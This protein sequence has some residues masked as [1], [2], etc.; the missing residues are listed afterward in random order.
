LANYVFPFWPSEPNRALFNRTATMVAGRVIGGASAINGMVFHRGGPK[1]Y[2]AWENLGNKGWGW[3]DL[4]KY[5]IKVSNGG[6]LEMVREEQRHSTD[7][8]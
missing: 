6:Q 3:K 5:F 8:R 2:D 4:K 1:D 7:S